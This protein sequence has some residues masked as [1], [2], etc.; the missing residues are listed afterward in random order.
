MKAKNTEESVIEMTDG[1][2]MENIATARCA[3]S[4]HSVINMQKKPQNKH[5]TCLCSSVML[6]V[7]V[8]CEHPKRYS[9]R[10]KWTDLFLL[11]AED[12]HEAII[13]G[14]R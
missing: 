4:V 1:N 2:R 3:Q 9:V 11:H 10:A 12:E 14:W 7:L 8:N 13:F 6:N 5:R